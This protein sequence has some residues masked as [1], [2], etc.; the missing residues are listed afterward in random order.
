MEEEKEKERIRYIV[1]KEKEKER[2]RYIVEKTVSGV[3]QRISNKKIMSQDLDNYEEAEKEFQFYVLDSIKNKKYEY[4]IISLQKYF[5]Y[6]EKTS[7]IIGYF[8][9]YWKK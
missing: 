6:D 8:T 9:G 7:T 2:I 4:E 3:Y 5:N 1:E